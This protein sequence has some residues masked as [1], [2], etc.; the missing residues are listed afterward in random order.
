M[1]HLQAWFIIGG[2]LNL[3]S[4]GNFFTSTFRTSDHVGI[5]LWTYIWQRVF[6][7]ISTVN[8]I[9]WELQA[10][11][12]LAGNSNSCAFHSEISFK[13]EISS[14][15]HIVEKEYTD[16]RI[17]ETNSTHQFILE[18]ILSRRFIYVKEFQ[19]SLPRPPCGFNFL[20]R[21]K[22]ATEKCLRDSEQ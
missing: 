2:R 1:N 21:V 17:H 22:S 14:N 19:S 5:F 16:E 4:R 10:T 11:Y 13:E 3:K 18:K 7:L 15:Q 12:G 9:I 6:H 20:W 8:F